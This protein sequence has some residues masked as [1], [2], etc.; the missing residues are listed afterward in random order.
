MPAIVLST[1]II[2]GCGETNNGPNSGPSTGSTSLTGAVKIDGSSTVLPI[3]SAAAE[4]FMK[5][6]PKVK[7]T[8]GRKGTG[9]GFK[10]FCI[11]ETDIND[12][13]RPIKDKEKELSKEH[14]IEYIELPVGF[15]GI[16]VL[17][18]PKNKFVDH[19][20]V[21]ELRKIWQPGSTVTK[22][23]DV[24][25]GWPEKEIKLYG[26]GAASGTFDYFTKVINGEEGASRTD[27]T[28]SEDDNTLVTGIAG[29]EN[30]L[31]YFGFAYYVEN[32]DKLK[33][34]PVDGGAGPIAPSIETI[35]EGTYQ[36]LSRPV[37]IYVNKAAAERA[38]VDQFVNFYLDNAAVLVG[39]VGY[40]P[41]SADIYK[42]VQ[43]R[44]QARKTGSIFSGAEAGAT[45]EGILKSAE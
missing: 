5:E 13:S 2:A 31:G 16:S 18:N 39:E 12:A 24:R 35:K 14:N 42:M 19:F 7:V 1:L 36:P 43:A 15:D 3:S 32:K 33:L 27:Y 21:E 22:W 45:V 11:E 44:Y 34:V 23:S 20:T 8:V 40:I 38:E 4:E 28:A 30:S 17:V 37:F 26:P 6:H 9:G 25:Q 10:R 29:D 41:F